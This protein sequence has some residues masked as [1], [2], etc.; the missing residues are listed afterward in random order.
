MN[1][2]RLGFIG[3]GGIAHRH[4]GV[5][6]TMEDVHIAAVCDPDQ[7]RAAQAAQDT[8]AVA[9]ADHEA[10]LAAEDLDAVYIRVPPFAQARPNAPASRAARR[11]SSK[12]PSPWTSP[13]PRR[14]RRRSRPLG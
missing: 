9:H 10:M 5:L 11:S 6:R 1:K 3:A 12:S 14:L 13:W 8:G 4:F 7:A 2:T